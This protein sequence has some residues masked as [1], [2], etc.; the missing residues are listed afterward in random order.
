MFMGRISGKFVGFINFFIVRRARF[1]Y[2]NGE[3]TSLSR[4]WG[5][6]APRPYA[7][8]VYSDPPFVP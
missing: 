6:L 3:K 5:A 7:S 4:H 8:R 1:C 2:Q